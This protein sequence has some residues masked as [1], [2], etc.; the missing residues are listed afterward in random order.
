M[1]QNGVCKENE[2]TFSLKNAK[3]PDQ[4]ED[5]HFVIVMMVNLKWARIEDEPDKVKKYDPSQ[6]HNPSV[7]G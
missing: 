5:E 7:Q 2:I 6:L 1:N 4:N 3:N